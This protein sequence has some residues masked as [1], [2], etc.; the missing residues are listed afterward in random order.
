GGRAGGRLPGAAERPQARVVRQQ[1]R[2]YLEDLNSGL[3]IQVNDHLIVS[4]VLL[5][6]ED[7]IRIGDFECSFHD[8]P[9]DELQAEGV[10]AE[11]ESGTTIRAALSHKSNLFQEI[12]SAEK[13]KVILAATNSLSKA[14]ELD[15]LLP[16]IADNLF[17]LF[18]QADRCFIILRE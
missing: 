10:A 15:E 7:R 12:Q 8:A 1:D 18:K 16:R 3:G 5:Q 9:T 6:D 17:Q 2:W 4:R 13:L 14:F 11:N